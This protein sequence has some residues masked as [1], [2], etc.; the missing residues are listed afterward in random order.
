M[1][2]FEL[3]RIKNAML[4]SSFISNLVGVA[5]VLFVTEH[6]D[7]TLP[8]DIL[9]LAHRINAFHLPLSFMLPWAFTLLYERP[10][11][12][13]LT[14]GYDQNPLPEELVLMAHQRLLNEPFFL[15]TLALGTWLTTAVLYSGIFWV[16]GAAPETIRGAFLLSFYTGLITTTVAFFVSEYVLQKRLAP[17]FF[18]TGGLSMT[19]G[20]MRIRIKTRLIAFLLA[21]NLIPLIIILD[22]IWRLSTTRKDLYQ[23]LEHFQ[24]TMF[25]EILLFM[26]TSIWLTFL[27][28]ANLTKPLGEIIQVLQKVK[29]GIFD[30]KVRVTSNDEIGYTGDV[31]NE[32]TEGLLERD[33]LQQSLELAREIQKNLLPRADLKIAGFDIAGKSVYC[34]ATGGDYYDFIHLSSRD[35]QKAGVVIADVSGHGIASALLMATVRSSLR[36]RATQPGSTAQIVEA[37]N[38]QLVKDVEHSGD[39]VTLFFLTIDT[40]NHELEWVRA[41]HEPAMVYDPGT[42]SFEELGGPGMALGIEEEWTYHANKRDDFSKGQVIFI[43]TDGVWEVKN[44]SGVILGIEPILEVIRENHSLSSQEIIAAILDTVARYQDGARTED[45]ITLV[46]IKTQD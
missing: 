37:V 27:V 9:D 25:I 20:T 3:F 2:R 46:I 18:P 6:S 36:Q 40:A 45:D 14:L 19:P 5:V 12:S 38:R 39:F 44:K 34:D 31:I 4:F 35:D 21:S 7:A 32:M 17:L 23:A 16:H 26:G 41:G 11:R 30:S 8:P 1:T 10:I 13:Y 33:R 29:I 28:S 42:D 22:G 15:I 43:G 24:S